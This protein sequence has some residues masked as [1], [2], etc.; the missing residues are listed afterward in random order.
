MTTGRINQVTTLP[1]A[2]RSLE[3]RETLRSEMTSGVGCIFGPPS[4]P[5][6]AEQPR[7]AG[8][9][10][11]TPTS[12]HRQRRVAGAEGPGLMGSRSGPRPAVA[13]WRDAARGRRSRSERLQA[14]VG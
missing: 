2:P 10:P 11:L 3:G 6:G 13:K 9:Q 4:Y 7:V 14:A 5:P 8:S 12:A 1:W